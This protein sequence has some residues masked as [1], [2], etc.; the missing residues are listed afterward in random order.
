MKICDMISFIWGKWIK[1]SVIMMMI[2]CEMYDFM[3]YGI[4]MI[5]LKIEFWL[6]NYMSGWL[7]SIPCWPKVV[8]ELLLKICL[9]NLDLI[10]W[11][12]VQD[13]MIV[14]KKFLKDCCLFGLLINCMVIIDS[15]ESNLACDIIGITGVFWVEI[16]PIIVLLRT[17]QEA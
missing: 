6:S 9:W 2:D 1:I 7:Y 11:R 10:F 12:C 14:D 17:S 8:F 3:R 15:V 13:Y 4:M 5:G 16:S